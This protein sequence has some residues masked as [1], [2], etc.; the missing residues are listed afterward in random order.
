MIDVDMERSKLKELIIENTKFDSI[1][2]VGSAES[3][4]ARN[5]VIDTSFSATT[6]GHLIVD[7]TDVMRMISNRAKINSISLTDCKRAEKVV[8]Y[9]ASVATFSVTNCP[10]Y[11]F[12]AREAN[13]GSLRVKGGS[14]TNSK[15][16]GMK[17]KTVLLENVSLDGELNFTGAQIG[18][19]K[20]HNL[21]QQPGLKLITTGST[22]KF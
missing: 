8:M 12:R 16:E 7:N 3:I 6:I 11:D 22:V 13:I 21:T 18:D 20:T 14:I 17:A 2:D 5:S 19:L 15:F 10:L 1:F 4:V 9:E